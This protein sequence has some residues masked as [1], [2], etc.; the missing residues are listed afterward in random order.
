[1]LLR[2]IP[3]VLALFVS[4][5]GCA[6]NQNG[7]TPSPLKPDTSLKSVTYTD[8]Q[9]YQDLL[10]A[11][12]ASGE[13]LAMLRKIKQGNNK[14]PARLI[15]AEPPPNSPLSKKITL[16]WHGPIESVV[17]VL[18]S[19]VQYKVNIVGKGPVQPIMVSMDAQDEDVYKVIENIG[20]QTGDDVALVRD[21]RRREIK[22][23]YKES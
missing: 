4:M 23:I 6:A 7:A 8:K 21:D 3:V 5:T 20:W 18:A 17:H 14:W 19:A 9:V 13:N 22:L 1:M 15:A 11:T 16:T 2:Y 12:K 10:A